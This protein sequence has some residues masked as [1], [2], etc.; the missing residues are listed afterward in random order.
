MKKVLALLLVTLIG[1]ALPVWGVDAQEDEEM[2]AFSDLDPG[3]WTMIKP[4]GETK[5]LYGDEYAFFARPAATESDKLMIYFQG[6]GACWDGM[7]CAA[8]GMFASQFD[9]TEDEM[10]S[11]TFGVF[12]FENEA[13][14]V[15]DYNMVF[16]P[17]CSGDVF[18]GD[19]EQTFELSAEVQAM[20]GVELESITVY[21]N[22]NKN[23]QAVLDWVYA[24]FEAPFTIFVT[25]SSAGGYGAT[26]HAPDVMTHYADVKVVQLADAANGV[27]PAEWPGFDTWNAYAP[28]PEYMGLSELAPE[29][30]A[31]AYQLASATLFPNNTFAQ[32]NTFL[33][34]TQVGF[35]GV[36][37][38][39]P[40]QSSDGAVDEAVFTE[41]AGEWSPT[42]MFN[43]TKLLFGADNFASYVAGGTQHTILT[44][45]EFYTYTVE[46]LTVSAWVAGLLAGEP[47]SVGCA[48]ATGECTAVSGSTAP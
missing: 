5:C 10:A 6:G 16:V 42:M 31:T 9:V 30:Y 46:D 45:P 22:G 15:S 18:L 21:F 8:R 26:R 12:D 43:L 23:A 33:D 1:L 38:G 36:M 17:Y 4:G 13:N 7:T 34:G 47:Q 28:I 3:E 37:T 39:R 48:L 41:V 27:I 32:Y 40:V 14:P 25:G 29:T 19:T 11:Q 24:N 2:P 35:Y 44:R 20:L